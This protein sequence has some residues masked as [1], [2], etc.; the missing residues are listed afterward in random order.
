MF[1][2]VDRSAESDCSL[3]PLS[4]I[5]ILD[6]EYGGIS[7][8]F[9][10]SAKSSTIRELQNGLS[11]RTNRRACLYIHLPVRCECEHGSILKR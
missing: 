1:F 4:R 8:P 2:D 11:K 9:Q 5:E 10:Q 3:D 7:R 6:A